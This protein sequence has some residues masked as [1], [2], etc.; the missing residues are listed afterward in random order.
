LETNSPLPLA[1]RLN[2]LFLERDRRQFLPRLVAVVQLVAAARYVSLA[3][4]P[5]GLRTEERLREWY[6]TDLL[7]AVLEDSETRPLLRAMTWIL[8]AFA[9]AT[10]PGEVTRLRRELPPEVQQLI[11]T[12]F[13]D[14][15]GKLAALFEPQA[16]SH[17]APP[18][19]TSPPPGV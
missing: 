14:L 7:T 17:D 4:D 15:P 6:D 10:E 13:H 2:G 1:E 19:S 5:P 18:R 8:L 9:R 11:P 16:D 12:A 3:D